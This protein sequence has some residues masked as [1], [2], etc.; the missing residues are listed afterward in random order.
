[1]GGGALGKR[2]EM[3]EVDPRTAQAGSPIASTLFDLL[4][5]PSSTLR[6]LLRVSDLFCVRL[7][8]REAWRR[9]Q[10]RP[11]TRVGVL[12]AA[13]DLVD[14]D[15]HV[16]LLRWCLRNKI[17]GCSRDK[18]YVSTIGETGDVHLVSECLKVEP[19]NDDLVESIFRGAALGGHDK[20]ALQLWTRFT[21]LH[22][23]IM[24]LLR[25]QI[26]FDIAY[27]GCVLTAAAFEE[28]PD[29]WLEYV[30][31]A[32]SKG[33]LPFAQWVLEDVEPM[34]D[35]TYMFFAARSGSLALVEWVDEMGWSV[36]QNTML[37]AAGSGSIELL[38]WLVDR[39]IA[40]TSEAMIM[41]AREGHIHVLEWLMAKGCECTSD[42]L[43]VAVQNS[44]VNV[45]AWLFA[46]CAPPTDVD[47]VLL[48]CR[49]KWGSAVFEY[50]VDVCGLECDPKRCMLALATWD[51][52]FDAA[53]VAK[54]FDVPLYTLYLKQAIRFDDVSCVRFALSHGQQLTSS[55]Y[56][57]L[58]D[59]RDAT[60]LSEVL[61]ARSVNGNI[62]EPDRSF[63]R[64]SLPYAR[65]RKIARSVLLPYSF[66]DA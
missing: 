10:H 35:D 23:E 52:P 65:S 20:L 11:L 46:R 41:A 16:P 28:E 48:S 40:P 37:S 12:T 26:M 4:A 62:P 66:F 13:T 32:L 22:K 51:P 50:L 45:V 17:Y 58:F 27:G 54:R 9:I 8:C 5:D 56:I 36:D 44:K 33:H 43:T 53:V 18:W 1:M 21:P 38:Q 55:D 30:A 42:L 59:K 19:R 14:L 3:E 15:H 39:G 29:E 60:L 24:E 64:E 61:R 63:I 7:T 34:P 47:L 49:N 25:D 31:S 57:S 2:K 6:S